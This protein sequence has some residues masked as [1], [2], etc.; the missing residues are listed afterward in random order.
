MI[1]YFLEQDFFEGKKQRKRVLIGY[2]IVAVIYLVFSVGMFL[3]YRTLP[4]MSPTI[5]TV[6][7]EKKCTRPVTSS[8][9]E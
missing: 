6:K 5:T 8:Q 3:W 1:E 7:I 2:I 4:Y 9:P